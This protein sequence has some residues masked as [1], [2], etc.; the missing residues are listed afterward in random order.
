M[1]VRVLVLC[2]V[3]GLPVALLGWAVADAYKRVRVIRRNAVECGD[4]LDQDAASGAL[5][6]S[7][8]GPAD[9]QSADLESG[10]Q[11]AIATTEDDWDC[12]GLSAPV[13]VCPAD[14][15]YYQTCWQ[16]ILGTF[17]HFPAVGLDLAG[18]LTVNLMLNR[19][20][21]PEETG[22]LT[23]LPAHWKF[24]T[25][26]GFREAQNIT[27]RAG[28]GELSRAELSKGLMLYRALFEEVLEAPTRADALP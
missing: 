24:P 25:A 19:G 20:V 16:H 12:A 6:S 1:A 26:Q 23:D 18:H 3:I 8:L 4:F 15:E 5:P 22:L 17:A 2:L 13:E 9:A 10:S 27:R 21:M 11:A 7:D 14:R 28:D